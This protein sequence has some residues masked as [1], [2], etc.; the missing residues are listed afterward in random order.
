MVA[1]APAVCP[2]PHT[3]PPSPRP[4][5]RA[6]AALSRLALLA[7]LLCVVAPQALA[8]WLILDVL[9]V[10]QGDAILI[11]AGGRVVLVD[12]GDRDADTLAQLRT[13]GVTGI[14]LLVSSHPH[15]DHIGGMEAVVRALPTKRLLDNGMPHSTVTYRR[16]M[17]AIEA[18][19]VQYVTAR[20]GLRIGLGDGAA[21]RVIGPPQPALTGTRSD[22][23]S[24]S[25]VLMLE[26]G[27]VRVL[28]TGDAE[29]PTEAWLATQ[30]LGRVDVLKV[31]HHGSN[32]SSTKPFLD[33]IQPKVAL[34]SCGRSNRY[35]HP[36][37]HALRRLEAA[38]A[39]VY[40]TDQSRHIRL[41]S[42]GSQ[43]DLF[44]GDL[45]A[46]GPD[47]PLPLLGDPPLSP[48]PAEATP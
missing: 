34:I 22:L 37:E 5:R 42:D 8:G 17:E 28:L 38:G 20:P 9:D 25:V 31:A 16:F 45:A 30:Q 12:A 26:H 14:D 4:L 7:T 19:G 47:W 21:L 33:A 29:E 24:N 13:L 3:A 43:I 48:S 44:E 36:G 15:A 35:G 39:T 23:N 11:R 10:G 41:I 18:I 2:P 32:H 1:V 40:R 27:E 6:W 46:L